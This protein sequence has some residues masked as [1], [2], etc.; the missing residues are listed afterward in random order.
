MLCY[1]R[2]LLCFS[3]D[4]DEAV[5]LPVATGEVRT[6]VRSRKSRSGSGVRVWWVAAAL[7]AAPG[8][9]ATN[10]CGPE[11][12]ETGRPEAPFVLTSN[13]VG[14]KLFEQVR[15]SQP[16]D[17]LLL[18]PFS[19]ASAL[20]M[21][22][23]GAEGGTQRE[24]MQALGAGSFDVPTVNAAAKAMLATLSAPKSKPKMVVANSLWGDV[25]RWQFMPPYVADMTNFYGAMLRGIDFKDMPAAL[26]TINGWVNDRTDKMIP[27]LLE[28]LEPNV[29]ALLLNASFFQGDWNSPFEEYATKPLPFAVKGG[30][31]AN[32]LMMQ[33]GSMHASYS[34]DDEF[35]LASLAFDGREFALDVVV[36]K[37]PKGAT[38]LTQ[39]KYEAL[40]RTAEGETLILQVPKFRFENN[41]KLKPVLEKL[42]VSAAFVS[43]RAQFQPMGRSISNIFISDVIQG[44]AVEMFEKGFRAA[45]ATAVPMATESLSRPGKIQ[46]NANR[47]FFIVLR[48]VETG[49]ALKI[50][51]VAD[52]KWDLN[53]ATPTAATEPV[54]AAAPQATADDSGVLTGLANLVHDLF[55]T[56]HAAPSDGEEVL[57]NTLATQHPDWDFVDDFK[58][59]V[60][61][62]LGLP[63]DEAGEPHEQ[64]LALLRKVIA[65]KQLDAFVEAVKAV[66]PEQVPRITETVDAF[67]R[68]SAVLTETAHF[69]LRRMTSADAAAIETFDQHN[70]SW[71]INGS[72]TPTA[73]ANWGERFNAGITT[74]GSPKLLGAIYLKQPGIIEDT[75]RHHFVWSASPY[76]KPEPGWATLRVSF[77]NNQ[78]PATPA[79]AETLQAGAKL[80]FEK[81]AATKVLVQVWDEDPKAIAAVET[82]GF[83]LVGQGV[84]PGEGP[85]GDIP[86]RTYELT[87][88]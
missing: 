69:R 1:H 55:W 71:V 11:L 82:A 23:N 17:N 38:V 45:A 75:G 50:G 59:F 41:F 19:A 81:L 15:A 46:V 14:W 61:L 39:T 43:G 51:R 12:A 64:V 47:P 48:H 37:D 24:L 57:R 66:R 10:G 49:A 33:D 62:N 58:T 35:Q 84:R 34:E 56:G 4:Q 76:A 28:H 3:V 85:G 2:A 70:V 74:K 83:K 65:A 22:T 63:F 68:Q 6:M 7:V 26:A 29:V 88:P 32:V 80:A 73:D 16:N 79:Y 60:Y 25:N 31:L 87:K 72:E 86:L 52:P 13:R 27:K 77:V 44:T 5:S 20:W 67:H 53:A 9:W 36:P 8:A 21:A 30:A 40:V 78:V 42:G 54:P 18:S